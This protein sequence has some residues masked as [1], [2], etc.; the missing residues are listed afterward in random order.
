MR[1]GE[2]WYLIIA[3]RK[4][5]ADA[6]RR[7]QGLSPRRV[8]YATPDGLRGR[9]LNETW[10]IVYVGTWRQRKDLMRLL[11]YVDICTVASST[12]PRRVY[13]DA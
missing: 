6:Y 7:Q 13:V 4:D 5:E 10:T 12:E 11:E 8:V 2:Q 9:T 1:E 3:G